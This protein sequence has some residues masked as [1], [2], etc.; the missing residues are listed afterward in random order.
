M[1]S[2]MYEF[3]IGF[4]LAISMFIAMGFFLMGPPHE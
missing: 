1:E 2:D 3:L 4:A